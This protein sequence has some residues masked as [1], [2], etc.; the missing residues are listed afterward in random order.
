MKKLLIFIPLI[1]IS[2]FSSKGLSN[3]KVRGNL[4]ESPD[5]T[6]VQLDHSAWTQLLKQ[7]V[8]KQGLVDYKGFRKDRSA[9]DDYV[10]YLSAQNPTDEWS[11]K[12]LLAFYI[13]AYNAFTVQYILD[14]YPLKSIK[15]IGS[16]LN[17]PFIQKRFKIGGEELSLSNIEKGILTEMNEPR[18]HFAINCASMSCPKLF[19]EAY[20]ADRI[21][22]Q[23]ERAT[24]EFINSPKNKTGAN[25]PEVSQIFKWYSGDFETGDRSVIDFINIYADAKIEKGREL[26][27]LEYD[28]SLNAAK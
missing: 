22:E 8:T 14:K 28:W 11:V 15:D 24:R 13:N 3:K 6:E 20:T 2:C 26:H 10:N 16:G 12:E 4:A 21:N 1:M 7:H 17:D 19:D 27:Y 23:L 25:P 18:I 9:L 5:K